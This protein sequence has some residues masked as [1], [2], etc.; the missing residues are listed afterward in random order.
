M[1]YEVALKRH[2]GAMGLLDVMTP[3]VERSFLLYSNASRSRFYSKFL[4]DGFQHVSI[5]HYDGY[6]WHALEQT[7]SGISMRLVILV[8][9][10]AFNQMQDITKYYSAAGFTVQQVAINKTNGELRVPFLLA[11]Q[12]CTEVAKGFL[13][14]R[15]WWL[16]T[17][18]SLFKFIEK[19][20]C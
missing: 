18:Y 11:P 7:W 13:R 5:L 4:R 20:G 14:I 16:F 10:I 17:P 3:G 9:G 8:G 2:V 6:F 19:R 12:T 1:H 15:K